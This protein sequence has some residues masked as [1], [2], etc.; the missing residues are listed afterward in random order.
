MIS[1]PGSTRV[2]ARARGALRSRLENVTLD[3]EKG[4]LAVLGTPAD[5]TTALLEVL[6]GMLPVRAG[7]ATVAGSAPDEARAQVVYV[8]LE[9]V[10]P[11]PLRVSEVCELATRLRGEPATT[12]AARLSPLGIEALADRRVRSLSPGRLARYRSRSP[13]RRAR[14]FS[15]RGAA[16]RAGAAAPAKVLEVLRARAT[17]GACVVVTTAS[18]R[19]ATSL[20]DQ[21]GM[22]TQGVFTH[23]PPALAHV[24]T[25]AARLRVVVS[26]SAVTEVAPFVSALTVESA[27]ATVETATFAGTR[28]IHAAVAVVVSGADLLAVARAVG[29]AAARTGTNVLRSSPRSAARRHSRAHR[30]AP[31]GHAPLASASADAACGLRSSSSRGR[32]LGATTRRRRGGSMTLLLARIPA[33][34]LLRTPRGWLPIVAWTLLAIVIA[35]ASRAR[36]ATT[37]ADHVMRGAFAFLV[38]PL[39]AY[40]VVGATLG[41]SGL[42]VGIRGV[43]ALGAAPR[44]AALAS[45]LVAIVTAAALCGVLG[46]L[47]CALAHGSQDPPLAVDM[48]ASLGV[49][50]LGGGTY[51]AYFSLDSRSVAARCAACSSRS[52]G[53]SAEAPAPARSSCRAATSRRSSA[54]RSAR[55]S[56]SEELADAH[57]AARR[58]WGSPCCWSAA[59]SPRIPAIRRCCGMQRHQWRTSRHVLDAAP[60]SLR[61]LGGASW[62]GEV[63]HA[64]GSYG[65]VRFGRPRSG[66]L[67]CRG[68]RG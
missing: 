20:A 41:R 56:R 46:A 5:G 25:S 43:V 12:A 63:L 45:V 50:A 11:D 15:C 34:R 62:W 53:S 39:V 10:L 60:R 61:V 59:R 8:P 27:I 64:V 18:V 51:A 14:R 37:G 6:A 30:R 55:S 3:W 47:V 35:L 48:A 21:L 19:D 31:T 66:V 38:L 22:L 67:A 68:M 49:G 24:G 58:V 29:A 2:R 9:P 26:A 57:R 40:G 44:S 33:L 32:G 13:S 23:L 28:V 7:T 52:T 16:R 42:R 4:V 65:A 54:A 1:S 36:G 17:A